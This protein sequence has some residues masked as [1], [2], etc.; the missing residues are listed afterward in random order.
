MNPQRNSS[1][2][3]TRPYFTWFVVFALLALAAAL[4]HRG[5]AFYRLG[6]AERVEHPDYRVLSPVGLVGHG[7]GIVGT[8]MM[9]TNLLYLVR[10]RFPSLPVGS[11]R[12]WLDIHVFTGLGGA[13]LVLFHSAF[14]LR[15]PLASASAYSV[16]FVVLTGLIGRN[17]VAFAPR[18]D[19][20]RLKAGLAVIDE[21]HAG[22]Q[23]ELVAAL[24]KHRVTEPTVSTSFFGALRLVPTWRREG[25]ER[26]ELVTAR[27]AS[28][29]ELPSLP[30]DDR[31]R[32]ET[33]I[34]DVAREAAREAYAVGTRVVLDSWRGFHRFFAFL[35][36]VSVTV[37]VGV[38]W[39]YGFRWI[40]SAE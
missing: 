9:L 40:F 26:R 34:D 4:A 7:Y 1:G 17:M 27:I 2:T 22:L 33:A 35:L 38:A 32:L 10:R 14:Q 19:V 21:Y 6:I 16:L 36:V 39:Y 25:G 37:H 18:A 12:L 11:M 15:T 24:Q 5:Y 8:L 31:A 20:E 29:G 30:A 28:R 23:R 13:M 3:A